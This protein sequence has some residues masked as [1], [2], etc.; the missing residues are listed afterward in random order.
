MYCDLTSSLGEREAEIEREG[1]RKKRGS[2]GGVMLLR[3]NNAV[4]FK[5][6]L[7]VYLSHDLCHFS[8]LPFL[9][10]SLSLSLSLNLC[11]SL[12]LYLSQSLSLSVP[13]SLTHTLPLCLS[14]CI[15]LPLSFSL[16]ISPVIPSFYAFSLFSSASYSSASVSRCNPFVIVT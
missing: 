16:C 1:E 9:P 15:F 12:S 14:L 4:L 8:H 5:P 6:T 7:S 11:V 2:S 3:Y 10:Q 13:F